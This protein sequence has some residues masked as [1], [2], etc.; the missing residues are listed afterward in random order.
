MAMLC[1]IGIHSTVATLPNGRGQCVKCLRSG[2]YDAW[3]R[4]L[5]VDPAPVADPDDTKDGQR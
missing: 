5:T 3:S 4:V 1:L 2:T